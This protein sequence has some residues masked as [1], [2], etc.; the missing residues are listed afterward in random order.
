[1]HIY[2]FSIIFLLIIS[3]TVLRRNAPPNV[4][5]HSPPFE[6]LIA[7]TTLD[8]MKYEHV[9]IRQVKQHRM[10][11]FARRQFE[12]MTLRANIPITATAA[13]RQIRIEFRRH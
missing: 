1:M 5:S 3:P 11:V 9:I 6:L 2:Q 4:E 12:P 7:A 8:R 10:K 13:S